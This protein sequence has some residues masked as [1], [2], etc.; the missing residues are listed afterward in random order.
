MV[1]HL[2][3]AAGLDPLGLLSA[4]V[5]DSGA[6]LGRGGRRLAARRPRAL[7]TLDAAAPGLHY[8]TGPRAAARRPTPR[9]PRPS[10][11]AG[12]SHRRAGGPD[13]SG[14]VI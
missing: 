1:S 3:S 14:C 12:R 9:T 4:L 11:A 13:W 2:P 6:L 10:R 8:L 5:L 7:L